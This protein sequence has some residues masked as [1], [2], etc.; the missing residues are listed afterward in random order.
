MV[1]ELLPREKL[2]TVFPKAKSVCLQHRSTHWMGLLS[3]SADVAET[4]L[5]P[6]TLRFI[7]QPQWQTYNNHTWTIQARHWLGML[8]LKARILDYKVLKGEYAGLA[9]CFLVLRAK[10]VFGAPRIRTK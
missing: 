7:S 3:A 8:C 9:Q 2:N 10:H 6:S 4:H 5:L 1:W